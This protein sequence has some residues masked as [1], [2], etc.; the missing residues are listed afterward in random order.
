MRIDTVAIPL[1]LVTS[2]PYDVEVTAR[3]VCQV[4]PAEIYALAPA[5]GLMRLGDHAARIHRY[6]AVVA[7][8]E[9][10]LVRFPL[11]LLLQITVQL[12]RAYH[13]IQV[14]IFLH[15]VGVGDNHVPLVRD[16]HARIHGGAAPLGAEFARYGFAR[17]GFAR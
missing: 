12:Q 6:R 16:R 8:I 14:G 15:A 10:L 11:D 13:V 1:S 5:A 9:R 2:V 17:Y 7:R 3:R 4:A